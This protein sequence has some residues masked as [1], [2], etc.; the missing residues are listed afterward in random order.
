MLENTVQTY[1]GKAEPLINFVVRPEAIDPVIWIEDHKRALQGKGI[2][3]VCGS[4]ARHHLDGDRQATAKLAELWGAS[5]RQAQ[6]RRRDVIGRIRGELRDDPLIRE[7][8]EVISGWRDRSHLPILVVS[9]SREAAAN[10][11]LL[12]DAAKE[13]REFYRWRQKSKET[14]K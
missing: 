5:L 14:P 9:P 3:E 4:L 1:D 6:N 12:A 11:K 7:L 2:Y 13:G 10:S 8:F